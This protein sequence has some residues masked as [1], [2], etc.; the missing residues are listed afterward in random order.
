MAPNFGHLLLTVEPVAN[1]SRRDRPRPIEGKRTL[2]GTWPWWRGRTSP[3]GQIH[4]A[5]SAAKRL[6]LS[7][8]SL[9]L[10]WC[11]QQ[12]SCVHHDVFAPLRTER[13][14]FVLCFGDLGLRTRDCC[15]TRILRKKYYLQVER[16]KN[17]KVITYLLWLG[18][19]FEGRR[20]RGL[21]RIGGA[22]RLR[23]VS[24][25][26]SPT[27]SCGAELGNLILRSCRRE[28]FARRCRNHE[29]SCRLQRVSCD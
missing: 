21:V 27:C 24:R 14:T 9:S 23:H 5:Q 4:F 8:L 2:G 22:S 7:A 29:S 19:G 17:N 12:A 3:G 1:P 11:M 15:Y 13:I 26:M 28:R 16:M 25:R 10:W 18:C 6:T 20:R